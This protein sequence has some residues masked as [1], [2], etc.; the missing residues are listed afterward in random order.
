MRAHEVLSSLAPA[1]KSAGWDPVG[2]QL[3]DPAAEVSTVAVCHE[4]TNAI[5]ERVEQDPPD[6]L[7]AYHPLLFRPIKALVAGSSPG[8]RALRLARTG[9][10][11]G[12]VHTAFDVAEGGTA[13]ALALAVGLESFTGFGLLEGT[14]GVKVV[15]FVPPAQLEAVFSAMT[16]A[17]AGSIGR[18]SG[19]SYRSSGEGSFVPDPSANPYAG[20]PGVHN[21]EAEVRLEMVAPAGRIDGVVNALV[22]AHPYEE[23]AFDIIQTRSNEGFVG[24]MGQL[25]APVRLS[26]VSDLLRVNLSTG[27]VRVAG[28]LDS[29]VTTVAVVPGSGSEF[30]G[31]AAALGVD[32]L[33]T[34]DVGHHRAVE[35]LD[36]GM[37]I[38]DAGHAPTERPGMNAL[39]AAVTALPIEAQDLTNLNTD[40]WGH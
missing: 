29:Q 21:L 3:G 17:G 11:L 8:G 28:D 34:G 6:L 4:V 13:D 20:E 24:R 1:N 23:P 26:A 16:A 19:C 5:V 7:V 31:S 22:A 27:S 18:Y 32:L 9:V 33:I 2:V 15:T 12:V 38:I 40:P 37:A 36:K 10:S 35:A 39:Y 14:P 30:I 25:A